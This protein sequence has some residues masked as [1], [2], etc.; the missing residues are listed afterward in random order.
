MTGYSSKTDVATANGKQNGSG[1]QTGENGTK[2]T[3][4]TPQGNHA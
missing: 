3:E 4:F 2:P 1:N